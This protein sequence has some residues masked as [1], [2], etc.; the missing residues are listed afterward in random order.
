M[1]SSRNANKR[2]IIILFLLKHLINI[3]KVR[4]LRAQ[5]IHYSHLY[6]LLFK[7]LLLLLRFNKNQNIIA[8]Q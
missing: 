4:K 1:W 2:M 3:E 5:F 7:S 8:K 6:H